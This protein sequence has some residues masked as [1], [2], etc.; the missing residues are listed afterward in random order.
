[1]DNTLDK[2]IDKVEKIHLVVVRTEQNVEGLKNH[3]AVQNGRIG[4]LEKNSEAEMQAR[5]T[6]EERL[7]GHMA[8]DEKTQ[9]Q[10]DKDV[11]AITKRVWLI[12]GSTSALT[13][14]LLTLLPYLKSLAG[15]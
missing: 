12:V 7:R 10:L 6:Y 14:G 11:R 2:L 1:M 8:T 9:T 3:V 5:A 13:G 15:L 4:H